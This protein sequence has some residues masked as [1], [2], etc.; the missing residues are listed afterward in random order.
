MANDILLGSDGDLSFLNGDLNLG[1]SD[2]Q[3]IED[4]LV[5]Q[6]G[7]YKQHPLIGVDLFSFLNSPITLITRQKLEKEITLQLTSDNAKNIE[8]TTS[9]QGDLKASANYE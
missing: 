3:H 6:K 1:N 7:E 5:A 4:I 9:A 2:E 8:I